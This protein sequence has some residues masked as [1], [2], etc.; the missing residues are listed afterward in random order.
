MFYLGNAFYLGNRA[1]GNLWKL[2]DNLTVGT[3]NVTPVRVAGILR[4]TM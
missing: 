1:D 3:L 4:I 2:P